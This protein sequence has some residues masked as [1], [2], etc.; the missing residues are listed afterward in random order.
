MR[1]LKPCPFC[2]S[3]DLNKNFDDYNLAIISCDRGAILRGDRP[4]TLREAINHTGKTFDNL[5]EAWNRR[6]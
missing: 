4:E 5:I 1:E 2:G 3:S 6:V